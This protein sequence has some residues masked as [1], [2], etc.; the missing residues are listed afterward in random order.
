[1][2]I[3]PNITSTGANSPYRDAPDSSENQLPWKGRE[4]CRCGLR[5][6]ITVPLA[7][8]KL[9]IFFFPTLAHT[10]K[11]FFS[12]N[13]KVVT[14]W[15]KLEI[16]TVLGDIEDVTVIVLAPQLKT[17]LLFSIAPG[18]RDILKS[19]SHGPSLYMNSAKQEGRIIPPA[20]FP[21]YLRP[22]V[23]AT[24]AVVVSAISL[25]KRGLNDLTDQ[26]LSDH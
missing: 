20:N 17:L 24:M 9:L 13:D 4:A 15:I 7:E 10:A 25:T 22:H 8:V 1:M 11:S 21:T 23:A 12:D 14:I 19:T 5:F 26:P 3:S 18:H 6:P 16:S 2:V